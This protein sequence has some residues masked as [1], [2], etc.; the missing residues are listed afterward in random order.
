MR[1][2]KTGSYNIVTHTKVKSLEENNILPIELL[3][4]DDQPT[5][6]P[7]GEIIKQ[8]TFLKPAHIK[9]AVEV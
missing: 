1:I 6:R 5:S 4:L 9:N 3:T 7:V 2:L 8:Y